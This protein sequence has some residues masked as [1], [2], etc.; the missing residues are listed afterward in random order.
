MPKSATFD[1]D[2]LRLIFNATA[3]AN[4]ADNAV[5]APLTNL[6]LALHTADPGTAGTQATSEIVYTGYARVSLLRT[7]GGWTVTG[8]SVSPVATIS[9]PACT[10]GT[11]IATHVSVGVA[12]SGATKVLYYGTLTPTIS[13]SNGVTPQIGSTSTITES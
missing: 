3:V 7:V 1:N 12:V 2:L 8:A 4:L 9:F 5:T 6:F 11:G 13:V 10:A